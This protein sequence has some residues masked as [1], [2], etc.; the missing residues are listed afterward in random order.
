V[1]LTFECSNHVPSVMGV[2]FKHLDPGTVPTQKAYRYLGSR[3]V[4]SDRTKTVTHSPVRCD[5]PV[6]TP[7]QSTFS[8]HEGYYSVTTNFYNRIDPVW[9]FIKDNPMRQYLIKFSIYYEFDRTNEIHGVSLVVNEILDI[10]DTQQM[11]R[12]YTQC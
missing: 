12:D 5:Q 3:E 10:H 8:R 7:V 6:S 2:K 11:A 1:K 9:Q 4:S